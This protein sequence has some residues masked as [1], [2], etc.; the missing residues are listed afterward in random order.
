MPKVIMRHLNG[1]TIVFTEELQTL[2]KENAMKKL[3]TVAQNLQK[4]RQHM[5]KV[6]MI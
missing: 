4:E 3:Q 2:R 1:T 5:I 6:F